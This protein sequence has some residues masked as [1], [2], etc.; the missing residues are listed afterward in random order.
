M[1]TERLSGL[2]RFLIQ[3]G[4]IAVLVI[5]ILISLGIGYLLAGMN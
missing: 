2:E 3:L 4:F 5:A 1:P